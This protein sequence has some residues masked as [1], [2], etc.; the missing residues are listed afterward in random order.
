MGTLLEAL[1]GYFTNHGLSRAFSG[2]DRCEL[3]WMYGHEYNDFA[4]VLC[5]KE[6]KPDCRGG[7]MLRIEMKCMVASADESKA[8]FAQIEKEL[9]EHDLLVVLVWD[10]IELAR[11]RFLSSGR[12]PVHWPGAADRL[13][14]AMRCTER[15]EG[16]L[17]TPRGARTSASRMPVRMSASRLTRTEN[18]S[19]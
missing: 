19:V 11:E 10:W 6:W 9:T 17:W 12:Q 15:G 5:G 7:E 16:P 14:F 3:A 13:V 1:W 4:L 2:E 8:H 18:G